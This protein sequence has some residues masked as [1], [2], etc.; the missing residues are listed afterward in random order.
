VIGQQASSGVDVARVA[1]ADAERT[2]QPIRSLAEVAL[3]SVA[4]LMSQEP[5]DLAKH[6]RGVAAIT[7]PI[8]L[9]GT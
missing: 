8:D 7:L 3:G 4:G 1:V 5:C 6:V 9:P 2:N